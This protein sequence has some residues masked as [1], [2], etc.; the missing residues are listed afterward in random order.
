MRLF[1]ALMLVSFGAPAFADLPPPRDEPDV[2]DV[3]P[4]RPAPVPEGADDLP[5]IPVPAPPAA[6]EPKATGCMA[7]SPAPLGA[8]LGGAVLLFLALRSREQTLGVA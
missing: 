4:P 3:P 5:P 7:V 6:A 1:I 2:L 8:G